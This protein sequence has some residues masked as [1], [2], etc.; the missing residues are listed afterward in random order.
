[1]KINEFFRVSKDFD[2]STTV[3]LQQ[4]NYVHPAG[5][6]QLDYPVKGSPNTN[7]GFYGNFA[8]KKMESLTYEETDSIVL[9]DIRP[10]DDRDGFH[11]II[12]DPYEIPSDRSVNFYTLANQTVE[13]LIDPKITSIDDTL[14]SYDPEE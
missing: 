13:Y 9:T 4:I 2:Y 11:L 10:K 5:D 14:R 7:I 12:H 8:Q 1:L 6:D 3:R